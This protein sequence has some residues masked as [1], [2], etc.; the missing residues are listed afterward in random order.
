MCIIMEAVIY[1]IKDYLMAIHLCLKLRGPPGLPFVGHAALLLKPSCKFK[2]KNNIIRLNSLTR[3]SVLT[4]YVAPAHRLYGRFA[5]AWLF[6]IPLFII[7]DPVDIQTILSSSKHT[8]KIFVYRFMH[9]FLGNGLITS[10]GNQ[11]RKHRRQMQ[12]M[13]HRDAL[14]R[15][16]GGFSRAAQRMVDSIDDIDEVNVAKVVN[17]CV[18]DVLNGWWTF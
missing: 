11:W 12:P 17:A 16:V 10:N 18:L 3:L 13:F 2:W 6:V 4:D 14:E 1:C 9:N 15:F 7:T 5:R 8:D